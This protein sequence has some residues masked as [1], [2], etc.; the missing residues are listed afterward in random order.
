MNDRLPTLNATSLPTASVLPDAWI[1]KIFSKFEARYGSLFID[2]WRD[3]DMANVRETWAEELAGFRDQ[4][5]R[6]AYA[7]RVLAE[8]KFPPTLPEFISACRRAP[9]KQDHLAR[10]HK[11]TGEDHDRIRETAEAAIGGMRA[12]NR[13]GIDQHWAT[14]PRSHMHLKFIFDA[15]KNDARFR[16]CVAEMVKDGICTEGGV[17]LKSYRDGAF[18]RTGAAA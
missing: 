2:R 7:L 3:C 1:S 5:D 8:E 15:A 16:P 14:H 11:L 9:A 10:P 18:Y 4:P 12:K 13:D 6:I 17:L